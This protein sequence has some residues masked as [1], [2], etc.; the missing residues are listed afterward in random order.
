[1]KWF[2]GSSPAA[3]MATRLPARPTVRSSPSFPAPELRFPECKAPGARGETHLP[4]GCPA[5]ALQLGRGYVWAIPG[6]HRTECGKLEGT[7]EQEILPEEV[8]VVAH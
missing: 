6:K 7:R 3:A 4:D 8:L 1:M 2:G 5:R